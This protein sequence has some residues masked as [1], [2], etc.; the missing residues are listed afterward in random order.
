MLKG[1]STITEGV[2][3]VGIKQVAFAHGVF[4]EG[5]MAEP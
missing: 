1:T 3:R 4:K 5:L 2:Q